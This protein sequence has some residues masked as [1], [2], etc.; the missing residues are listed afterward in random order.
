MLDSII[1]L[2]SLRSELP[3]LAEGRAAFESDFA[4]LMNLVDDPSDELTGFWSMAEWVMKEEPSKSTAGDAYPALNGV[5][6]LL[7]FVLPD[8]GSPD[9]DRRRA[10][11][12]TADGREFIVESGSL[13]VFCR[14]ANR[15]QWEGLL[16][17]TYRQRGKKGLPS[18]LRIHAGQLFQGHYSVQLAS[19]G[20]GSFTGSTK[21]YKRVPEITTSPH[22]DFTALSIDHAG[23]LRGEFKNNGSDCAV[24]VV[25]KQRRRWD[26][27]SHWSRER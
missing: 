11:K 20:N 25:F 22:G 3:S 15:G 16:S 12:R 1:R 14:R 5:E 8:M 17:L 26:E 21:L 9:A 7:G 23:N 13:T 6:R 27:I 24:E 18:M 10:G 4:L 19:G 2:G